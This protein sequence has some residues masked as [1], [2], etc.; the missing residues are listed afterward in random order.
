M[1]TAFKSTN[2]ILSLIWGDRNETVYRYSS[3]TGVG[4]QLY[5]CFRSFLGFYVSKLRPIRE[6]QFLWTLRNTKSIPTVHLWI[7]GNW[8]LTG[9]SNIP[10]WL[11]PALGAVNAR[12]YFQFTGD[13][14]WIYSRVDE[15]ISL[16]SDNGLPYWEEGSNKIRIALFITAT[17]AIDGETLTI[18]VDDTDETKQTVLTFNHSGFWKH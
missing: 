13:T 1:L 5:S 18:T 7:E 14:I 9:V 15:N 8:E 10:T 3:C 2:W 6:R 16:M 4:N 17:Y 11:F 12:V